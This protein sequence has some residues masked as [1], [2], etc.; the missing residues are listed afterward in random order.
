MSQQLRALRALP[1]HQSLVLST[2]I[3]WL[4]NTRDSLSRGPIPSDLCLHLL[5]CIVCTTHSGIRTHASTYIHTHAHTQTCQH[6]YPNPHMD[7]KIN[8]TLHKRTKR[9]LSKLRNIYDQKC[10]YQNFT[11]VNQMQYCFISLIIHM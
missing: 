4:T 3:K 11:L 8:N 10:V 1:E 7:I 2:C 6:A 5:S 9:N